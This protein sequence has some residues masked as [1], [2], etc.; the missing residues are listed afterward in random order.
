MA[1]GVLYRLVHTIFSF[2]PTAVGAPQQCRFDF[3]DRENGV[4]ELFPECSTSV[5]KQGREN[6]VA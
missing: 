4:L 2:S 1:D 3:L 6:S 5:R